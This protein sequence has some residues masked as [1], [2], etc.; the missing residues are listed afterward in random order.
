[1]TETMWETQEQWLDA[2][3]AWSRAGFPEEL[4]FGE[5][6]IRA[7]DILN[8]TMRVQG[9]QQPTIAEAPMPDET[10]EAV[11]TYLVGCG[12]QSEAERLVEHPTWGIAVEE[13]L[14]V[15]AGDRQEARA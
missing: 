11:R 8:P 3:A 12:R 4:H 10:R 14:P 5:R 6:T 7:T 13:L 2:F 15:F 1:M 9:L